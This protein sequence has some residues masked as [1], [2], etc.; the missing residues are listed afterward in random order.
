M[1]NQEL[2][3]LIENINVTSSF[4]GISTSLELVPLLSCYLPDTDYHTIFFFE[5]NASI[6]F[7]QSSL[8]R[9]VA[10]ISDAYDKACSIVM[11]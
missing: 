7:L 6:P 11:D 5:R 1:K 2:V 10:F 9:A 8:S 3:T 4:H